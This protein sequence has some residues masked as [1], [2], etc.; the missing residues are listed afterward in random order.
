MYKGHLNNYNCI[1]VNTK[2]IKALSPV[3]PN[4]FQTTSGLKKR[5]L[6]TSSEIEYEFRPISEVIGVNHWFLAI[7]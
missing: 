1:V 4:S 7:F 5:P 3:K 2:M 6:H